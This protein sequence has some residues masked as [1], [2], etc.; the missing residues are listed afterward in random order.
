MSGQLIVMSGP[1]GVGKSTVV[2]QIMQRL[3]NLRFSVSATTRPIRP[4]EVNGVNYYFVSRERF[5]QMI[6]DGELLEYTNYVGNF[7]GTPEK[8]LDEALQNGYDILLD[9]EVEG[10]LNVKKRRPD[11]ILIFVG[12]PSFGE[13]RHRLENRGDTAPDLIIQRLERAKWEYSMA[14]NYDYLVINDAV[15]VCS[16]EI[17]SIIS[18]EKCRT[19]RRAHYLKEEP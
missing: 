8:P 1:S 12:A 6:D 2:K 18:A 3:Q 11:A 4:G 10:A 13:L 17:L 14:E 15:D 16:N 7:Y 19:H 9:I 5:A